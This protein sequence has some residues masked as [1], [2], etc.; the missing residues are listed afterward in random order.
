MKKNVIAFTYF[1][2]PPYYG[3][4]QLDPGSSTK[5]LKQISVT[6]DV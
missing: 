4:C 6:T 5:I 1:T 2:P 3:V